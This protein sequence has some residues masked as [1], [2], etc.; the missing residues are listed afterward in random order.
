MEL[1]FEPGG[2]VRDLLSTTDIDITRCIIVMFGVCYA[3]AILHSRSVIHRDV[4][5]TNILLDD[6]L[7][8]RL[9][10][11]GF[12]RELL[13]GEEVTSYPHTINYAPPE[14]LQGCRY[15]NRVDVYSFGM[16]VYE[17]RTRQT[18]WSQLVERRRITACI[19]DGFRPQMPADDPF[20]TV[21]LACTAFRPEDRPA[22]LDVGVALDEIAQV[23]PGVD[24]ALYEE[25]RDRILA[26]NQN[27]G[28]F[29]EAGSVERLIGAAQF[30][31]RAMFQVA[32]LY[33]GGNGVEENRDVAVG[34]F[35]K[36]AALGFQSAA[37][38]YTE[39]LEEGE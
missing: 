31:C 33:L 34:Y 18:P 30:S 15:T 39:L 35:Q 32:W 37:E 36:A 24:R 11:F 19:L 27:P 14:L 6:R 7:E 2:T 13:P 16:L 1:E 3:L 28:S 4:K 38:A 12:A 5:A 20:A 23:T 17:M 10:D 25:Y 26:F 8:P 21:Y 9:A 22:M 29:E